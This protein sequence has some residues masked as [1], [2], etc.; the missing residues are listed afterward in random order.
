MVMLCAARRIEEISTAD[1]QIILRRVALLGDAESE[2]F[3]RYAFCG[4]DK[5]FFDD[6]FCFGSNGNYQT[7][8]RLWTVAVG[9][10]LEKITYLPVHD[11]DEDSGADGT[12]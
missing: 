4:G 5:L 6:I 8:C 2:F 9:G 3:Y 11:L 12:A 10:L 7:L 1:P